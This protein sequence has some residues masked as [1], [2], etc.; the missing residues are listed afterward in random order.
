MVEV[1][2]SCELNISLSLPANCSTIVLRRSS[3]L[4][5]AEKVAERSGHQEQRCEIVQA[6]PPVPETRQ[7]S[8]VRSALPVQRRSPHQQSS[9]K[10]VQ[11]SS[12]LHGK[13]LQIIDERNTSKQCSRYGHLQA[14]P[15]WKRT[16]CCG[17]CGIVRDRNKNCAYNILMRFLAWLGPHTLRECGV[18]HEDQNSGGVVGMPCSVQVQQLKWW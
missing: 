6:S 9:G 3:R 2:K 18:L 4:L 10:P 17:E 14:M 7:K 15:L 16:Y 13:D 5:K 1:S 11:D 8:S 12:E